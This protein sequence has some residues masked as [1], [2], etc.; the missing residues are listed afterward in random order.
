MMI[1]LL[2]LAIGL[3]AGLLISVKQVQ[4]FHLKLSRQD[5]QQIAFA[6]LEIVRH[7]C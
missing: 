2:Y 3:L 4:A 6:I 7:E 1:E 5:L